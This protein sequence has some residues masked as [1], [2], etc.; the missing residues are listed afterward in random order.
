MNNNNT[1]KKE[2][3]SNQNENSKKMLDNHLLELE[4]E[5]NTLFNRMNK[6]RQELADEEINKKKSK[7]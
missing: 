2:E 6:R 7:K 4:D 5:Y 1:K 3:T